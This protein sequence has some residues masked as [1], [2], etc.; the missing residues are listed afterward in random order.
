MNDYSLHLQAQ[1]RIVDLQ[2][3]SRRRG[4]LQR[5][6]QNLNPMRTDRT[7]SATPAGREQK[8]HG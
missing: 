3:E 5:F 4:R 2:R 7:A 1:Y 8:I 6:L